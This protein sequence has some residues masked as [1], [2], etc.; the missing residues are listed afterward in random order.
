MFREAGSAV[1][2]G[3]GAP[4]AVATPPWNAGTPVRPSPPAAMPDGLPA[5]NP[6]PASI[7]EPEAATAVEL[8]EQPLLAPVVPQ[9]SWAWVHGLTQAPPDRRRAADTR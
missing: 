3:S 8:D 2:T 6:P 5:L 9:L 7:D 4:A 1:P